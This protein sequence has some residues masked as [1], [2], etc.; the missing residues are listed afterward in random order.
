MLSTVPAFILRLSQNL[1]LG[2]SRDHFFVT[3][4]AYNNQLR[5][6]TTRNFCWRSFFKKCW[7]HKFCLIE[8]VHPFRS[9][10]VSKFQ[11]LSD[12]FHLFVLFLY[13]ISIQP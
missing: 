7:S 11:A 9:Y 10:H 4:M 12:L 1:P 3:E 2:I 6:I 8:L 5:A 13:M